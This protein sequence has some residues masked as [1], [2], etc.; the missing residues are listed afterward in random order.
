MAGT[1][2]RLMLG[3][4]DILFYAEVEALRRLSL[5]RALAAA[6]SFRALKIFAK[7]RWSQE[8]QR[9][10]YCNTNN[11]GR[12][13]ARNRES[14]MVEDPHQ[15]HFICRQRSKS[16]LAATAYS[17]RCARVRGRIHR[18]EKL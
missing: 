13:A 2:H 8:R 18:N 6:R 15:R 16:D 17:L 4:L 14:R 3:R 10:G 12:S 9:T 5:R 11:H 7:Y 1:A